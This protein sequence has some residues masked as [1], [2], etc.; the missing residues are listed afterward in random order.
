MGQRR[1]ARGTD[2][3]FVFCREP[4][5]ESAGYVPKVAA[6][7]GI[8]FSVN[9]AP[10]SGIIDWRNQRAYQQE[11]TGPRISKKNKEQRTFVRC[12]RLVPSPRYFAKSKLTLLVERQKSLASCH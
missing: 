1:G 2:K 8:T 9:P 11:N 6:A 7:A 12:S 3:R 4:G 5:I 10:W